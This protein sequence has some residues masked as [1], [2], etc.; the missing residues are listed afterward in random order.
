MPHAVRAC[1]IPKTVFK[2]NSSDGGSS[3]EADVL[4]HS[5]V[6]RANDIRSCDV[7]PGAVQRQALLDVVQLCLIQLGLVQ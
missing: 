2:T 7:G 6:S 5:Y 3:R 1:N 4:V